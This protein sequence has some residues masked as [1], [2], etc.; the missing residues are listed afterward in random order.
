MGNERKKITCAADR[1]FD[2]DIQH[3][4]IRVGAV[5]DRF[6]NCRSYRLFYR[7]WDRC[8]YWNFKVGDGNV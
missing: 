3:D 5:I 2:I 4:L 1:I 8:F 6:G 7:T